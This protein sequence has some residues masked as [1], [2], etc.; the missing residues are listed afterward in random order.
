MRCPLPSS[1]N[2]LDIQERIYNA[3][4]SAIERSYELVL[5]D[6]AKNLAGEVG[7]Y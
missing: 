4:P 3:P 5:E 7:D 6:T 2:L 1:I